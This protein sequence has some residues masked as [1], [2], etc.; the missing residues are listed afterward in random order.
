[1]NR[2]SGGRFGRLDGVKSTS[3]HAIGRHR[4]R[5]VPDEQEGLGSLIVL[6][7][8]NSILPSRFVVDAG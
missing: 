1:V 2:F 7:A 4:V 6:S 3:Q 5:I 8:I